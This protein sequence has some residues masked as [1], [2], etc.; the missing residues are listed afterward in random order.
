MPK[1]A[2]DIPSQLA[3]AQAEVNRALRILTLEK[4]KARKADVHRKIK[5][6]GLVVKSGLDNLSTTE[7]LGLLLEAKTRVEQE[8]SCTSHWQMLGDKAMLE[9]TEKKIKKHYYVE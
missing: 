9:D 2:R 5:L 6:G 7:L 1:K 3:S 8:A 4:E